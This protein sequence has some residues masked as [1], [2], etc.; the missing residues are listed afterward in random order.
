MVIDE[1]YFYTFIGLF[2][3]A[4]IDNFLDARKKK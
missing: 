4:L 2:I 1:I 3:W